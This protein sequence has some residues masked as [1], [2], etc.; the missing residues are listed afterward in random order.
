MSTRPEASTAVYLD[1]AATTPVRSE[2]REAMLPFLSD[3][4]FGNP[5]SAHRIGRAARAA[6][7]DA[8][9]R[10]G[11]AL[12]VR[13]DT[14]VFTSGGTE[15]D[16]L[17]V[18]GSALRARAR[19]R[20]F[21][22]LIGATEHKA[23]ID[24]AHAVENLG[25]SAVVLPVDASGRID[26]NALDAALDE[27]VAVLSV[28]WVNNE[29]GVCQDL[30]AIAARARGAGVPFHTDAV[31][32]LGKVPWVLPDPLPGLM[33]ISGHKI[34]APKGIGALMVADSDAVEPLIHGGGQQGGLRPGTEN[35]AG[36]VGLAVAVELAVGE[37][38]AFATRTSA[39]RDRLEEAITAMDETVHIHGSP[40]PR[41]PHVANVAFPGADANAML[42][43]LDQAGVACSAGSACSSGAVTPSH[44]LSAMG[45]AP[46]L[47]GS[48]V[49]FSFGATSSDADVGRVVAVLPDVMDRVRVLTR[50]LREDGG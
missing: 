36:A 39:L 35:V 21:R 30:D 38:P 17:A 25:G 13:P 16:N 48:S 9:Q 33:S 3:A 47:S 5:S 37:Q 46:E 41:A 43:H 44:V 11:T 18:L 40:A 42:L 28:M 4:A 34:G 24:A 14:V 26:L 6:L 31:Q 49:R 23:V 1:H 7:T 22:V 12:G 15:A 10:I 45:I 27:T 20:P 32:A 2:V 29:T 19:G 8:R 50:A